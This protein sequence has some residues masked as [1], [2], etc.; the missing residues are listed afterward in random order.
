MKIQVLSATAVSAVLLAA[1]TACNVAKPPAAISKDKYTEI[2]E[3]EHQKLPSSLKLLTLDEAQTIAIQNNPSFKS[4]YFAVSQARAQ[5]YRRFSYY[6]PTV[7]GSYALSSNSY[8]G[9][10]EDAGASY[11]TFTSSPSLSASLLVFDSFQREMN[12][13]AARHSWKQ[14]EQTEQDARRLLLQNVA[15]AYNNVMLAK[16]RRNIAIEDM[17][18]NRQLLK[19]TE[20][21]Y[22]VGAS[23]LSDVLNF[24]VNYNNAESNLYSA[25]YSL[26]SSKYALA[27]LMGLTEGTIPDD[28]EFP[29]EL[30][31]DG[32]MLA[33]ESVYL[34]AALSNRPD[35]KA[36]REALEASKFTYYSSIAAFGPTVTTSIGIGYTNSMTHYSP[37]HYESYTQHQGK[38][39]RR[40]STFT[41]GINV[42]WDLFSG[43]S[44]FFN[45]RASQAAMEQA[46][47]SLADKWIT[48]I[49]DVRT[50]YEN[51]IVS[52]KTVKLYQKNLEA[53]R[54]MRDLVD[55]EY[56]AGNCAITR[57]NEVQREFVNA[58]TYLAQAVVNMHNAKAQI[59]AATNAN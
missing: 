16:A 52:L 58:E 20:L 15:Y 50:A 27:A 55:D 3:D 51:Y 7:T 48:V 54:K 38:S 11:K 45:M 46:E 5:Y 14:S 12:L 21:K 32:E 36:L 9:Y 24:K 44:T 28:I 34:D 47:Y 4:R 10:T 26:A 42:S 41:S 56:E 49:N 22:G 17:R 1:L 35:L 13:L 40:Y 2:T 30:P 39:K 33:D 25:N 8:R 59:L 19:E 31:S 6:L 37:Y 57:V 53:V 43:G 29:E 18:Y 23:T